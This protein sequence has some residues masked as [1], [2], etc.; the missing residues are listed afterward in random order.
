MSKPFK[1]KQFTINQDRCAMK[2]GTDGVLLGAWASLE[3]K[4]RSILDIG[5]GTGLI[6][7]QMA[8]RSSAEIIDA[9]EID[10]NAYEQCVDNF[11][12]SDWADR[13]FCYHSSLQ[14]FADEIE[15][16]YDLIVTNPP[17][18]KEK[19]TSGNKS[20][21]TARQNLSLPFAELI[22]GV[23]K[24]LSTKGN[25][26]LIIPYKEE[27][28]F[29]SLAATYSLF[30]NYIMRVKGNTAT[31]YKRSL[32]QFSK[33]NTEPKKQQ[34]IIEKERHRYTDEY[35]DLMQNFYLKM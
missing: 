30:P 26:A 5:A 27:N 16:S 34:L 20:R 18:Y 15:D 17:F 21:D 12:A 25:F 22:Q 35:I 10:D 29:I 13:L 19:V 24:L 6:A 14:K 11:E 23:K 32:I 33:K 3:N 2:V 7:L 28:E 4:P 31:A 8:Q 9:I 1:F